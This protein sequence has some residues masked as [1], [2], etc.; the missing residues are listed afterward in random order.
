MFS[1][2][3]FNNDWETP[4]ESVTPQVTEDI[5]PG[6]AATEASLVF[7]HQ[8]QQETELPGVPLDDMDVSV[9]SNSETRPTAVNGR[10]FLSSFD[11]EEA[12]LPTLLFI[13]SPHSEEDVETS[14]E[15]VVIVD[16][17]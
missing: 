2:Q 17:D 3:D 7:H 1:S 9:E 16:F 13:C 10:D 5:L 11:F 6:I 14:A 4:S 15:I 12:S 8:S